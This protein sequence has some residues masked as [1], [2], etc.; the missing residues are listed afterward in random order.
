[1]MSN[2]QQAGEHL[3]SGLTSI[4]LVDA[5]DRL[6]VVA[7]EEGMDSNS[8]VHG[9][10]G[11]CTEPDLKTRLEENTDERRLDRIPCN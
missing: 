5:D 8:R 6:A 10:R 9:G 1:M 3:V 2:I 11:S 4:A 7:L